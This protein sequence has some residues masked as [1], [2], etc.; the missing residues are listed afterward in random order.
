MLRLVI[1]T[2]LCHFNIQFSSTCELS[3]VLGTWVTSYSNLPGTVLVWVLT[4]C[5]LRDPSL[6]S[7]LGQLVALWV[8]EEIAKERKVPKLKEF[9]T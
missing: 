6:L 2:H 3:L 5:I 9:T 7:K 8:T 1:E 4:S